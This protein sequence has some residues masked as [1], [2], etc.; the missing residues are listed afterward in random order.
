MLSINTKD[1]TTLLFTFWEAI[2]VY[3]KYNFARQSDP[4]TTDTYAYHRKA[5]ESTT[6]TSTPAQ[7]TVTSQSYL[8]N[9]HLQKCV[10]FSPPV[11]EPREE[12]RE[13][14]RERV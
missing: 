7:S 6:V 4:I 8:K 11:L 14:E 9:A 3:D 10:C 13:R 5:L 1:E 2:L 12:G